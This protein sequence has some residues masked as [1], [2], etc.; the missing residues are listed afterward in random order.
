M[1]TCSSISEST[2]IPMA[3]ME[4]AA[5]CLDNALL[6]L[7]EQSAVAS[8]TA[9]SDGSSEQRFIFVSVSVCN[10]CMRRLL[11]LHTHSVLVNQPIFWL[12]SDAIILI[13]CTSTAEAFY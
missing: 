7:P 8:T 12:H 3:T 2:A 13:L 4:F 11:V 6:L 1:S 10:H 9:A 5:L